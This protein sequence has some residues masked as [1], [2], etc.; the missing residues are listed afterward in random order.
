V[1]AALP[2]RACLAAFASP[3]CAARS[4]VVP[5]SPGSGRGVPSTDTVAVTPEVRDHRA[6]TS[7][8]AESMASTPGVSGRKSPTITEHNR[9]A[10]ASRG[11]LPGAGAP[12]TM[13]AAATS[14]TE[15]TRPATTCATTWAPK[16]RTGEMGVVASR[17]STL[18]SR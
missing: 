5:T 6:A 1:T 16:S 14:R 12:N 13:I 9:N 15:P 11:T 2:G 3:S 17:L 4:S 10:T 18:R 8:S 7:V